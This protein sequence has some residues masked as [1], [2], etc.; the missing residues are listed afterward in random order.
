MSAVRSHQLK[1]GRKFAGLTFA[2]RAAPFVFL[3]N[4]AV[5]KTDLDSILPESH[6][7]T[8]Q[9]K[10]EQGR[11]KNDQWPLLELDD[12]QDL[13]SVVSSANLLAIYS[14]LIGPL[15]FPQYFLHPC[16]FNVQHKS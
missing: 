2:G 15:H 7:A 4:R 10:Q 14:T 9:R 12:V 3:A 5:R 11:G 8:K 13:R 16:H 6:L 1:F